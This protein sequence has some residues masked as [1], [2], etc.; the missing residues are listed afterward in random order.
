MSRGLLLFAFGALAALTPAQDLVRQGEA[1]F[2]KSCAT[3]YCHGA[4]G[5]S[6]GAPRLAARGFD[7]AFIAN[8]VQRG[9]SGTAMPAFGSTLSRTDLNAVVAYIASL[10]GVTNVSANSAAA[11]AAP[12]VKL[13]GDA[14]RGQDLFSDSVRGFG[15]CS[16]CHEAGGIGIA[17]ST[18][19]AKVPADAAALKSLATPQVFT[20]AVSGEVMPALLISKKANA[21]VFYDL[22]SV[23]PV[24]RTESPVAAQIREGSTWRHASVI[25]AYKD[26]ELSAILSYLRTVVRP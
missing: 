20:A 25:G 11:G 14:A 1:V 19:I 6:G 17:V 4:R 3:G 15:R 12:V 21:I 16:T 10:N 2:A 22:T 8:T 7:R 24:L 23:P 5:T 26:A 18:P 9:I 13:A